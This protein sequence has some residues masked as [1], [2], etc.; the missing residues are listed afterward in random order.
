MLKLNDRLSLCLDRVTAGKDKKARYGTEALHDIYTKVFNCRGNCR[1]PALYFP[2]PVEYYKLSICRPARIFN[3][4]R[5]SSESIGRVCFTKILTPA[6][7]HI[8]TKTKGPAKSG[9]FI[10]L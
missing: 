3:I 2:I 4:Y 1:V 5:P 8:S 9:I 10:S 6:T 7:F